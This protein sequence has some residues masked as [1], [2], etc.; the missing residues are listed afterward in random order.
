MQCMR[1]NNGG[2]VIHKMLGYWTGKVSAWFDVDG[3]L[4]EAEQILL[5]NISR[6][7]KRD[8]P[9]WDEIQRQGRPY[10]RK[11]DMP[12]DKVGSPAALST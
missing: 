4:L 11:L 5:S 1:F 8:G 7:V 2:Y 12:R 3:N 10:F 6:G 9:M